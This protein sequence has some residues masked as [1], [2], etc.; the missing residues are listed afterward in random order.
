M[1]NGLS[2]SIALVQKS[3]NAIFILFILIFIYFLFSILFSFPNE[4]D[5]N[6]QIEIFYWLIINTLS[7]ATCWQQKNRGL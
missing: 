3:E 7:P 2:K 1:L 4:I 5:K 6:D